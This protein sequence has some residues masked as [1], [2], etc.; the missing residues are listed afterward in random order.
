MR[1]EGCR[2]GGGPSAPEQST[3]LVTGTKSGLV[4]QLGAF[5]LFQTQ[6]NLSR[7]GKGG[8][9]QGET[10][11]LHPSNP[12]ANEAENNMKGTNQAQGP[13]FSEPLQK[14]SFLRGSQVYK[15]A[16]SAGDPLFSH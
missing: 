11:R 4:L 14:K 6:R 2:R 15:V 13:L 5:S 7:V 10:L 8:R 9:W 12:Q 16:R 3:S 1:R